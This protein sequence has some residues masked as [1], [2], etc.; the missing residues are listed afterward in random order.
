[1]T[2]DIWRANT[3]MSMVRAT[4]TLFALNRKWNTGEYDNTPGDSVLFCYFLGCYRNK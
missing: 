1:M 2:S 4:V 3:T